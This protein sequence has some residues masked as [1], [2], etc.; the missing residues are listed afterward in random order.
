M[1]KI[2]LRK[3]TRDALVF[4]RIIG[5]R[6]EVLQF[7][8]L[9]KNWDFRLWSD[10]KPRPGL[11]QIDIDWGGAQCRVCLDESWIAQI[12]MSVLE[13][14][15]FYE[16]SDEIRLLVID[17]AFASA[18][19]LIETVTRKRLSILSSMQMQRPVNL[20]SEGFMPF[21]FSLDSGIDISEG[22]LW[23]DDT[24]LGFLANS[25]S[26]I[27]DEKISLDF[28]DYLPVPI[29]MNVGW[30]NL[31]I[32]QLN[33]IESGD[34][35]MLDESWLDNEG[36]IFLQIGRGI[37]VRAKLKENNLIIQDDL[38]KIMQDIDEYSFNN[39]ELIDN[40]TIKLTFDLGEREISLGEL[41]SIGAGYVFEMGRDVRHA[42]TIRANGRSIGEGELVD[43][44]GLIGVSVLRFNS[45][46]YNNQTE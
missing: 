16:L 6:K 3:L 46:T 18:S 27:S 29:F 43:I 42:V 23:V 34:V 36:I 5:T 4:H 1:Q 32:N 38:E 33:E 9:D 10:V 24:G 26:I 37:G 40:I 22:E 11:L 2:C 20:M 35:I 44:D 28:F 14:D 8:C 17:A 41:R 25:L 45:H 12:A 30:V 31:N 21:G 19:N 15:Y 39:D 13:Q 7:S